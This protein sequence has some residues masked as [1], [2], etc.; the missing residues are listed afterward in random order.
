MAR[1]KKLENP[2]Y[3]PI[4]RHKIIVSRLK[5]YTNRSD[6][7]T[8]AALIL[9]LKNH[10]ITV[11]PKT[12]GRDIK[13]LIKKYEAPIK[14]SATRGYYLTDPDWD[15]DFEINDVSS[16]DVYSMAF[17]TSLAAQFKGTPLHEDLNKLAKAIKDRYEQDKN[18]LPDVDKKIAFLAPPAAPV[19]PEIWQIIMTGLLEKRWLKIQYKPYEQNVMELRIAACRLVSLENEWY[20]FS[21]KSGDL[22]IRQLAVRN[23]LQAELQKDRFTDDSSQTVD[24]AIDHRFGWFACDR[25]IQQVT[26]VFD[27]AIRYLVDTRIW[28]KK[29]TKR[30]LE[31]GDLEISFPTS[32]DGGTQFRFFE[33][34]KW[35][36]AYGRFVKSVS[37]PK[38]KQYVL[39]DLKATLSN[40]AS[41]SVTGSH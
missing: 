31:N 20:L 32:S 36:L 27:K 6:P 26:V 24:K 35:I 29:Q 41:S 10:G 11:D 34:R 21:R 1:R 12:V 3:R 13:V 5:L 9:S 4:D 2:E 33:V 16:S 17:A 38:L 14:S 8:R 22:I 7:L 23:I 28:H 25:E 40:L 37:P 18:P 19:Q 15:C 39:D 30:D